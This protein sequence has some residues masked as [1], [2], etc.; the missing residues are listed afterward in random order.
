MITPP[1]PRNF[2]MND[3]ILCLARL[4]QKKTPVARWVT[5][6]LRSALGRVTLAHELS[7]L[8]CEAK[9]P[10]AE[11]VSGYL[12]IGLFDVSYEEISIQELL[13]QD[14]A[15][16][17]KFLDCLCQL[18]PDLMGAV[19]DEELE[20]LISESMEGTFIVPAY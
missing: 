5:C 8:G 16:G 1:P 18:Y 3:D 7:Y 6:E 9:D 13:G 2:A 19:I 17:E 14:E 15:S 4:C 12:E 20:P 11:L 10:L